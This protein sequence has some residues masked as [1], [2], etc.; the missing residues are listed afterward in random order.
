MA[1]RTPYPEAA[2]E[3]LR[4]TLFDAARDEMEKRPWSAVT[5]SDVAAA[6]GVSRQTLYKEFGN[7]S[8][9][10]LA[11]TIHEGIGSPDAQRT[12]DTLAE[13]GL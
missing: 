13:H 11:L 1:S 10:G 6:A 9:F 8:D 3:L 2:R 5:M 7:R 4:R 12:R